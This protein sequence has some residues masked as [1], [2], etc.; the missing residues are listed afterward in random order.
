MS[1]G[2]V[3]FFMRCPRGVVEVRVRP[4]KNRRIILIRGLKPILKERFPLS[5][6]LFAERS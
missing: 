4:V 5:L 2:L 3:Y 1:A 6:T